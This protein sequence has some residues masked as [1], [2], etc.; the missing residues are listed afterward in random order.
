MCK[1][2]KEKGRLLSFVPLS[3]SKKDILGT[4]NRLVY[5]M[6]YEDLEVHPQVEHLLGLSLRYFQSSPI[7]KANKDSAAW[8]RRLGPCC[9]ILCHPNSGTK[10]L[11]YRATKKLV[12]KMLIEEGLRVIDNEKEG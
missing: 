8:V 12:K 10:K 7:S 2:D 4:V 5:F 1:V 3:I 6:A 11:V 9:C